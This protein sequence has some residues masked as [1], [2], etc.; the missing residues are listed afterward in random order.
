MY[1]AW[2]LLTIFMTS[3]SY[4][5]KGANPAISDIVRLSPLYHAVL[6]NHEEA[7]KAILEF[8][9]TTYWVKSEI[10]KEMLKPDI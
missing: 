5:R 3:I 7:V 10:Y 1:D 4:C 9:P 8:F 6:N 2:A